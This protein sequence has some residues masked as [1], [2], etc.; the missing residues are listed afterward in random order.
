MNNVPIQS[1]PRSVR[2]TRNCFKTKEEVG[3]AVPDVLGTDQ[4]F[5]A[6]SHEPT[7]CKDIASIAH[8]VPKQAKKKARFGDGKSPPSLP[9]IVPVHANSVETPIIACLGETF[10]R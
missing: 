6:K 3:D 7:E 1:F 8:L 5:V 10:C 4:G 9:I 2:L